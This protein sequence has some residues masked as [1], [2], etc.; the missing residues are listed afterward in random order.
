[1][2]TSLLTLYWV[3]YFAIHSLLATDTIK[4]LAKS[5]TP[6]IFPYYRIAYNV[7]AIVGLAVLLRFTLPLASLSADTFIGGV[8]TGIGLIF[9]I[10]AF[11]TFN[12]REFL[13]FQT[14]TKSELVVTG[15]Y[16]FVRHPLY[17][18]TMIFI[19]GLYLLFP[20][21]SMLVVLIISY[22]YIWIGSRLEEQKLRA[23]YGESYEVYAKKVKSLI[24]YVY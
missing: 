23:V 9:I 16:R 7:I 18:G 21:E 11:R 4:V 8:I 1:M 14:E 24:P 15:M 19:A 6:S 2:T 20:S 12:L 13:G 10:L 22:A 5:K 17:F 3:L